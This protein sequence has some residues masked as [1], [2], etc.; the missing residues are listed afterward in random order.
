LAAKEIAERLIDAVPEANMAGEDERRAR[1]LVASRLM[2]RHPPRTPAA[3]RQRLARFLS[4]R[5]FDPDIIDRVLAEQFP[6]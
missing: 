1:S 6:E 4:Q 5:G 3:E 2:R